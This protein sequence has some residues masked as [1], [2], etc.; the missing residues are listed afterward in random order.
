MT[1]RAAS[2]PARSGGSETPAP[3]RRRRRASA[4]GTPGTY[5]PAETRRALLESAKLLFER[6]GFAE[7]TVQEIVEHADLTKGAFYHHFDCKEEMLRQIH[8]EYIEYQVESVRALLES[9]DD[10]V[11]QLRQLVFMSVRSVSTHRPHVAVFLQ[12]RRYLTGERFASVKDRRDVV[13]GGFVEVIRRGI[14]AG[15]F[16]GTKSARVVAFGIIG[17]SAWVHQWFDE[18]GRLTVDDIAEIFWSM[19]YDGL[20]TD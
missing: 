19:V 1:D 13:E 9:T 7:T 6:N 11:E 18:S 15:V 8:D 12:E 10:P 14:E 3:A 20:R 17:M 5:A 2:P 16:R 4:D